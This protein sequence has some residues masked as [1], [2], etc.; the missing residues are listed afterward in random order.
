MA[1]THDSHPSKISVKFADDSGGSHLQQRR[2]SLEGGGHS[3]L[4]NSSKTEEMVLDWRR[5]R[6]D[7]AP[8]QT[9]SACVESLLFQVP[10]CTCG[11]LLP[12]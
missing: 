3:L 12:W 4:L 7:P 10:Q 9:D 2:E 8:L 11:Q 6:V 5:K 1:C